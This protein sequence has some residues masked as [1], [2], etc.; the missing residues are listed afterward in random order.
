MGALASN[1]YSAKPHISEKGVSKMG[2][3]EEDELIKYL[4]SI[5]KRTTGLQDKAYTRR[6]L[7]SEFKNSYNL[8]NP[9][10]KRNERLY[11]NDLCQLYSVNPLKKSTSQKYMSILDKHEAVGQSTLTLFLHLFVSSF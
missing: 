5:G 7:P 4:I 8:N 1:S 9:L 2:K 10:L 3:D 6:K 11:I